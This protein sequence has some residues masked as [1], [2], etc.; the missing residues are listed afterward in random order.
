MDKILSNQ[1]F[2]FLKEF[3]W[4]TTE[5]RWR[6]EKVLKFKR[7]MFFVG[8]NCI[9]Y[10]IIP[11]RWLW[12]Q[13]VSFCS[14]LGSLSSFLLTCMHLS[15][16]GVPSTHILSGHIKWPGGSFSARERWLWHRKTSE[17]TRGS[18]T[19]I[20]EE[21]L[22]SSVWWPEK[23]QFSTARL[24][25]TVLLHQTCAIHEK[26]QYSTRGHM[27]FS[28]NRLAF[29]KFISFIARTT[30]WSEAWNWTLNVGMYI[31]DFEN[32]L[33]EQSA[34]TCVL[35]V[36]CSASSGKNSLFVSWHSDKGVYGSLCAKR[37]TCGQ[38]ELSSPL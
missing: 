8:Y 3:I 7:I 26:L 6:V 35:I 5:K 30:S 15:F 16:L 31:S 33:K 18:S 14:K 13:R 20:Q 25:W 4:N 32:L 29:P 11:V 34:F 24:G 37:L 10:Y 36:Y 1:G 9:L 27:W 22:L 17:G 38:M 28:G 19:F 2:I 12:L 23:G 21:A